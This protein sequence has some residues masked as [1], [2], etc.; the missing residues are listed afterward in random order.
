MKTSR[1]L[2]LTALLRMEK[3]EAYSNIVLNALLEKCAL[4]REEKSFATRLFYGVLE[5]KLI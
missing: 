5:K 4:G 2:C 1:E 3:D